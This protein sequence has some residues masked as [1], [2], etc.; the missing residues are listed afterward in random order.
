MVTIVLY[1]YDDDMDKAV[2][3]SLGVIGGTFRRFNSGVSERRE[4][5]LKQ[6]ADSISVGDIDYEYPERVA[7]ETGRLQDVTEEYIETIESLVLNTSSSENPTNTESVV[8]WLRNREGE[9]VF[10]LGVC[11]KDI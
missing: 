3:E 2:L 6:N 7:D 4:L 10:I 1:E 9:K 8:E 5:I 11:K